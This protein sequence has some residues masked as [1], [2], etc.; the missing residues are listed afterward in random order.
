[1]QQYW[2]AIGSYGTVGLEF[3]L[4]VIVGLVGGQWLDEK[5]GTGFLMWLGGAFGLAA[6]VRALWRA[7]QRANRE[8]DELTRKERLERKK[9]DDDRNR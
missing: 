1:M 7:L 2:K 9:Y 8:A 6:G 5:L 4:S 3:S